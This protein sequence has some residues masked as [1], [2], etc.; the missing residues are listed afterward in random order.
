MEC[1]VHP[2]T[3]KEYILRVVN[4]IPAVAITDQIRTAQK[5][6]RD[7]FGKVEFGQTA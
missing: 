6:G 4:H 7:L 1:V 3:Q 2:D 5:T